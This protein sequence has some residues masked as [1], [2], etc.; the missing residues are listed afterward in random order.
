M[1]SH[2]PRVMC[3]IGDWLSARRAG[4]NIPQTLCQNIGIEADGK[5]G[6]RG[7]CHPLQQG[8]PSTPAGM[9]HPAARQLIY[10][11][12]NSLF[13]MICRVAVNLTRIFA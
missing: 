5:A 9:K 3:F 11:D 12:T 2:T 8:V 4:D 13:L 1:D 7:W 10:A 6:E